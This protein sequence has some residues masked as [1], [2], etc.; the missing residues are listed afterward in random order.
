METLKERIA[1]EYSEAFK[2]RETVKKNLLGVVK[3]QIT[4]KEKND[5]V[6]NLSDV[7]VSKILNKIAKDL[8]ESIRSGNTEA[9]IELV[10]IESYLPKQMDESE[11]RNA[12]VLVITETG[13]SSPADMGKVM[14]AIN[15]KYA[16][17]VDGKTVSTIVKELLTKKP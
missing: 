2:N 11:V 4:T 14:T 10:I 12:V 7:E 5:V 1:K 13:A 3:G 8:R 16:G 15:L 17:Q 9:S 6:E